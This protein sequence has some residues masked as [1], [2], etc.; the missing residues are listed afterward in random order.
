MTQSDATTPA[1]SIPENIGNAGEL[2]LVQITMA[3]SLPSE[4]L[5][6][7]PALSLGGSYPSEE[8]QLVY[9]T[10]PVDWASHVVNIL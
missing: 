7:Y 10:T 2:H 8:M 3:E 6:S 4:R 9:S 5:M 1:Q